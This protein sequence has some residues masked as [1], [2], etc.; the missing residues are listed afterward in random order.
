MSDGP[1]W[2]WIDL[3]MTGL[4]IADNRIIELACVV[5]DNQLNIVAEGPN[6]VIKQD[7]ELLAAMDD[8]NTQHHTQSG[9]VEKVKASTINEQQAEQQMLEFLTA[10]VVANS[11]PMCGNSI[12]QDRRFLAAYMPKLEQ[13]FHYRHIDVS[14]IKEL[15]KSWHRSLYGGAS[16]PSNH[17][18]LDD[19]YASIEELRHYRNN[20]LLSPNKAAE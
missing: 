11:S 17:R 7:D 13:Y 19:V 12:C 3:E 8:W 6:L 4:S 5:T 2:I 9:L 20:W 10:H 14:T 15:A 16:K 18:A 1:R